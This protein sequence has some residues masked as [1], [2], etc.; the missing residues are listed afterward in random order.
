MASIFDSFDSWGEGSGAGLLSAV[1]LGTLVCV[2]WSC[3]GPVLI[4]GPQQPSSIAADAAAFKLDVYGPSVHCYRNA[5]TRSAGSP[6]QSRSYRRGVSIY[7]PV[8]RG[9]HT[10]V[11]TAFGDAATTMPTGSACLE[12]NLP[13]DGQVCFNLQLTP[14]VVGC[15]ASG[16]KRCDKGCCDPLFGVCKDDCT[17]ECDLG[18]ADCNGDASDGCEVNLAQ[19]KKKACG[20]TCIDASSCCA[21]D[22]CVSPPAPAACHAGRCA[23]AG[24]MCSYPLRST[25]SLCGS[26]CCNSIGGT[27]QSDCTIA[28]LPATG[29]C[30]G[31]VGDG[32][33]A[34]LKT[35]AQHCGACER[36]CIANAR[37]SLASCGGGACNSICQP[38]FA[39][40]NQ[41]AAPQADDG[42]ECETPGC[43]GIYCQVPHHDGFGQTF[44][45]CSFVGNHDEMQATAAA[46]VY[47]QSG[48]LVPK[49]YMDMNGTV[50]AICNQTAVDCPCWAYAGSGAY[51]GVTGYALRATPASTSNCVVPTSAS[52]AVWD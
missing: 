49:T 5:V 3:S 22:D 41:P 44:F 35:N 34:D 48:T 17:L 37:V 51:T 29:N 24:G 38:G 20:A 27:C 13:G 1:R 40:C 6:Q 19:A 18:W 14:P 9:Q 45:D 31:D 10:L 16:A 4:C 12:Q 46:R 8:P 11:L 36:A 28:C 25:S 32:C 52:G 47:N 23:V 42:C 43:C 2:S 50:S 30:N 15:A 21:D 7:L 33:E 39:N 26:T